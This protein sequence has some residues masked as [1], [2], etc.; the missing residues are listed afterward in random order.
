MSVSQLGLLSQE[1]AITNPEAVV[2][3]TGPHYDARLKSSFPN[4]EYKALSHT[5]ARLNHY[6]LPI[7]SFKAYHPN[8]LRR[9]RQWNVLDDVVELIRNDQQRPASGA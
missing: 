4:V 2:F 3:F 8:Y 6:E 1:I 9:S 7:S 5:L